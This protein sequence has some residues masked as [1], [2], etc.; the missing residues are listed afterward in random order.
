LLKPFQAANGSYDNIVYVKKKKIFLWVVEEA[1]Y[2]DYAGIDVRGK[3]IDESGN[4]LMQMAL[5]NLS[6]HN[7][8]SGLEAICQNLLGKKEWELGI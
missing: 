5:Y 4:L 3:W 2:S 1:N 8:K 6:A 7:G